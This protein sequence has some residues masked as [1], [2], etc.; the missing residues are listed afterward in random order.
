M[1]SRKA[2]KLQICKLCLEIE[3]FIAV[4]RRERKVES[5][6]ILVE[7]WFN[8]ITLV[9][10]CKV[11]YN[12]S[13]RK[14]KFVNSTST[15]ILWICF[16]CIICFKRWLHKRDLN[17]K[18]ERNKKKSES[19]NSYIVKL[20]Q[21]CPLIENLERFYQKP[22]WNFWIVDYNYKQYRKSCYL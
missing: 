13:Y 15:K 10:L 6:R 11:K 1:N 22:S 9:V 8:Y 16:L 4:K 20:Y 7:D 3:I 14:T 19:V 21:G 2:R 12:Q 5:S 18:S 17:K